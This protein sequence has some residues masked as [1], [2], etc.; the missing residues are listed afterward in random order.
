MKKTFCTVLCAM[1]FALRFSAEAQQPKKVPRIGFLS[2]SFSSDPLLNIQAF[3]QGLRD[4]GYLEGQNIII[5]Y[6][7]AEEKIDRLPQL[8]AE[9]VR[10]NP[11]VIVT[12]TTPGVL[13]AIKATT[14]IPIVVGAAGDLVQRGVVASLARPG[15]NITGLIFISRELDGKRLEL[16][17]E[18]APKISRVAY[19]VNPAN[20][21]W[22]RIPK[23]LEDESGTLGI[24]VYRVE[25]RGVD[26]FEA[27]FSVMTKSGV[28][29]LH[30]ANDLVFTNH[31]K[32]IAELAVK[33]RLPSIAERKEFSEAGGLIAYGTSVADMLR[34]AATHV[35]KILKGTKPGDIPVERPSKFEL[36]I[37]LKTAKQIGLTI[38]QS[39]LYRADRVI[40]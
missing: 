24:R 9:L 21:A 15:G 11:D 17:K 25:A 32:R 4:L 27:A 18:V 37:N 35:D 26:E 14:T 10:L 39:V 12:S 2:P 29:A 30:L 38:P 36:V 13:A 40:K 34:R 8:A 28:N 7:F 1:L 22:D 3:R 33:Q 20:P 19:L 31:R 6:R 5:E 16:L 23:D